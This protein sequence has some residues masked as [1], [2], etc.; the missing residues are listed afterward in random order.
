MK[1]EVTRA[2][3]G[4]AAAGKELTQAICKAAYKTS[5]SGAELPISLSASDK[6]RII[7]SSYICLCVVVAKSQSEESVYE[8]F[9]FKEKPNEPL[10]S[11][12]IDQTVTYELLSMSPSFTYVTLGSEAIGTEADAK[13]VETMLR[14]NNRF[15]RAQKA[16]FGLSGLTQDVTAGTL[17]SISNAVATQSALEATISKTSNRSNESATQFA[18]IMDADFS[19]LLTPSQAMIASGDIEGA[20]PAFAGAM[21]SN[22]D[23]LVDCVAGFDDY[24]IQ[25]ELNDINRQPCMSTLVRIVLRM[26]VAFTPKWSAAGDVM[27]KWLS[28]VVNRMDPQITP[29]NSRNTRLFFLRLLINQPVASIVAA[30]SDQILPALMR[31]CIQDLMLPKHSIDPLTPETQERGFSYLLRDVVFTITDTWADA[32]VNNMCINECTEFLN[33]LISTMYNAAPELLKENVGAVCT[34]ISLWASSEQVNYSTSLYKYEV[35]SSLMPLLTA[36][37]QPTGGA[38]GRASSAGSEGVRMRSSAL[39]VI[40]CMLDNKVLLFYK[41]ERGDDA[42]SRKATEVLQAVVASTKFP[43]QEVVDGA[44]VVI[45]MITRDCAESARRSGQ[46]PLPSCARLED[47]IEVTLTGLLS[48]KGGLDDG[49]SIIDNV[50]K[51]QRNFL[52]RDLCLQY[53]SSFGRLNVKSKYMFLRFL[54]DSTKTYEPEVSVL[55]YLWKHIPSLLLDQ[56]TVSEGRGTKRLR[57]SVVQLFTLRL[58]NKLASELTAHQMESLVVNNTLNVSIAV[59]ATEGSRNA[60]VLIRREAYRFLIK[61]FHMTTKQASEHLSKRLLSLILRGLA[62]PDDGSAIELTTLDRGL[63]DSGSIRSMVYE[64]MKDCVGIAG[65]PLEQMIALMTQYFDGGSTDASSSSSEWLKYSTYL[66]MDSCFKGTENQTAARTLLFEHGLEDDSGYTQLEVCNN[67]ILSLTI[68]CNI[69]IFLHF[70]TA[71]DIFIPVWNANGN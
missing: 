4:P 24:S 67:F 38:H 1:A 41:L 63:I 19:S 22:I 49:V 11:Y 46:I 31:C 2:F 45:G 33:Y 66:L 61:L 43:R 26:A 65:N 10:W 57:V 55:N 44:S 6:L 13:L 51:Y 40:K 17:H 18:S 69:L 68:K 27:P 12:V 70:A 8:N 58:L 53:L 16:R 5:R 71:T 56:F 30:W 39:K 32:P 52:G 9:L 34:L 47:D 35:L 28:E 36:T 20:Q 37:A 14:R 59:T 21:I 23:S 25:F 3:A 64:F 7:S 42:A 60:N 54:C 29:T 50:A 48:Q 15:S 62:D